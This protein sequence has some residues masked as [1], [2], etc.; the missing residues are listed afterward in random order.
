L[1][2]HPF[3]QYQKFLTISAIFGDRQQ[4]LDFI[5]D[6]VQR[7]EP[8]RDW[9]VQYG[10]FGMNDC[11]LGYP[12]QGGSHA[13]RVVVFSP[14]AAGPL[15]L[16]ANLQD[17]WQSLALRVS[18]DLSLRVVIMRFCDD[19]FEYPSRGFSVLDSGRE[20][21]SVFVN[22]DE[23]RWN[24]FESGILLP[25]E[26]PSIYEKRKVAD[27]LSNEYLTKLAFDLGVPL[28]ETPIRGPGL[29][30]CEPSL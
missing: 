18:R 19:Q 22:K 9:K 21:R 12:P 10:V 16:S 1:N 15:M 17:G 5:R 8:Q 11:F 30:L 2:N 28:T 13:Y 25:Q 3:S 23:R 7:I 27:R 24:F 20:G 4:V 26:T 14:C 29:L 6:D